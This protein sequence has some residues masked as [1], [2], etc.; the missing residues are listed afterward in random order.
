MGDL[1]GF[2]WDENKRQL[3]IEKTE[4]ISRKRPR[5]FMALIWFDAQTGT[6]AALDRHR[7]SRRSHHCR[8][9]HAS[10]WKNPYH[11]RTPSE[12]R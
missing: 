1:E 3:N 8:S 2:E 6:G 7:Q 5:Y 12:K 4:S 9:V 10:R 11:F